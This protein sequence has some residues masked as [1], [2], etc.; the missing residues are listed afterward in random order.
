MVSAAFAYPIILVKNRDIHVVFVFYISPAPFYLT[1]AICKSPHVTNLVRPLMPY[2]DPCNDI[3][4]IY[5]PYAHLLPY[6]IAGD[7]CI[8][9]TL[10]HRD[11]DVRSYPVDICV[12]SPVRACAIHVYFYGLFFRIQTSRDLARCEITAVIDLRRRFRSRLLS[13]SVV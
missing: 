9:C 6:P 4:L 3:C 7:C 8:Q 10:D 5:I 1:F 12:R 13:T 2:D 11:S